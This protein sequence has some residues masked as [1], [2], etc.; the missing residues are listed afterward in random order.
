M[1]DQKVALM[2]VPMVGS[3]VDGLFERLVSRKAVHLVVRSAGDSVVQMV[4]MMDV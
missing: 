3:M 2:A 4:E 1:V